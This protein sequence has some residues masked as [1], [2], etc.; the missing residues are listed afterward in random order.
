MPVYTDQLNRKILLKNSP[1]RIVSLVPSQTELLFFLGVGNAVVGITKFCV[2]PY[3]AT[4]K[5]A[6]IGG[7]KSL[8]L[9]AIA[10]LQPDLIIANKEEND[11][12][13]IEGLAQRFPVWI[14]DI[15]DLPSANQMI[16]QVGEITG[17]SS[18]SK[19]L[20]CD[21]NTSFSKLSTANAE[22]RTL[23]LIWR[24]PYMAAGTD[25]F[26]NEMLHYCGLT[27]AVDGTRY[28]ELTETGLINFNPDVVLLSSEPYP[29]GQTHVEEIGQ[30]LPNADIKL[31]D[32][33]MF[34]WYGSRLHLAADYFKELRESLKK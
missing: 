32:G 10:A 15:N 14:S 26:I 28:P 12:D 13:Q 16:L 3:E 23:Y 1:Q 33:E 31:V 25:T 9:H 20:V 8:D 6:K 24:K 11:R 18:E 30:L 29:F 34:S 2:H 7:T 17:K 4:K 27:N 19:R 22:R 5:V 21:I